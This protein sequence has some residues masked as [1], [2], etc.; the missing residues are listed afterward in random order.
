MLPFEPKELAITIILVSKWNKFDD[1][2]SLKNALKGFEMEN[3]AL[4]NIANK[5]ISED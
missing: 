4:F 1:F 2:T 5:I 3:I